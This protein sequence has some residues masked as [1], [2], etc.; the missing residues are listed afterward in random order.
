M[1]AST[2]GRGSRW[3]LASPGE[4]RA[5]V[6]LMTSIDPNALA[7]VTAMNHNRS[8]V[9]ARDGVNWIQ[10]PHDLVTELIERAEELDRTLEKEGDKRRSRQVCGRLL[11]MMCDALSRAHGILSKANS[12]LQV[13]VDRINYL[14]MKVSGVW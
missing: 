4:C 11:K 6:N 8:I 5:S 2:R 13:V 3:H 14:E 9:H 10:L 1:C 12:P 7:G